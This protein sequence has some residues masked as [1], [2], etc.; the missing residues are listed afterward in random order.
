MAILNLNYNICVP[1][2]KC[3]IINNI[4]FVPLIIEM[5]NLDLK[6]QMVKKCTRSTHFFLNIF[7]CATVTYIKIKNTDVLYF[8][9]NV[10]S[11]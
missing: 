5:A 8:Q 3:Y 2:K 11:F 4:N 7:I 1:V 6:L 10:I 9:L